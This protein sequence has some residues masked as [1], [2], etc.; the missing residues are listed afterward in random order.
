MQET[1]DILKSDAWSWWRQSGG[2]HCS[3]PVTS[4]LIT[5][6]RFSKIVD[7]FPSPPLSPPFASLPIPS[8]FLSPP[9]PSLPFPSLPCSL[10]SFP[11]PP[12]S[13]SP[14]GGLNP[15]TA[16]RGLGERLSSPSGSGRSPSRQA[17]SDAFW[18]KMSN[19]GYSDLKFF[20]LKQVANS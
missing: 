5:G 19:S 20:R 15:F 6:A 1:W 13:L 3:R 10:P 4:H 7:P 11:S 16:A 9:N 17:V 18:A 8:P 14:P 12:L 2:G